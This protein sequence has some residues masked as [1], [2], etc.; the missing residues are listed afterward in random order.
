VWIENREFRDAARDEFVRLGPLLRADES[1]LTWRRGYCDH[2]GSSLRARLFHCTTVGLTPAIT[3]NVGNSGALFLVVRTAFALSS[4]DNQII[5]LSP[6]KACRI[7][8]LHA[9]NALSN[10]AYLAIFPVFRKITNICL[11][12]A[13]FKIRKAA[14]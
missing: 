8:F 12:R 9:E 6:T 2:Q 7:E 11:P 13:I 1:I 5:V 14:F 4:P 3:P 10:F